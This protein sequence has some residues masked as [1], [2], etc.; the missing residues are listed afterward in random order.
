MTT[1]QIDVR[2]RAKINLDLKV[3]GR[4]QDGFHELRT[5][6]QSIE[7]HDTLSFVVREGPFAI[8]CRVPGVPL[9]HSNLV[10]RAANL[11]WQKMGRSG[12]PRDVTVTL[13]KKIPIKA[14]LGGGSSDAAATLI[15]LRRLWDVRISRDELEDMGACLGADVPFFLCGGTALGLG[16]GEQVYP[17]RDVLKHWVVLIVPDFGVS[18]A[19]AYEWYDEGEPVL[20]GDSFLTCQ[21]PAL[22]PIGSAVLH[23]DLEAPVACRHQDIVKMKTALLAEGAVASLLSGSGGSVFGLFTRRRN[24]VDALAALTRTGWRAILSRTV[25]QSEYQERLWRTST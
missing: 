23:N 20:L 8:I 9:D 11:L 6:L 19:S 18:T 4:H 5:V 3:L 21:S 1:Q 17:L 13:R 7:L 22:W 10:W 25:D 2:A 14:G 12:E 16:R 15:A 24:A